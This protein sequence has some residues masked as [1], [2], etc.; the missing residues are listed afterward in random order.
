MSTKITSPFPFSGETTVGVVS[1][2]FTDGVAEFDGTL[3][4]EAAALLRSNG[5]TVSAPL[6]ES[7][8]TVDESPLV[9]VDVDVSGLEDDSAPAKNATKAEWVDYGVTQGHDRGSLEELTRT[10]IQSLFED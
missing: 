9:P 1:L 10:E 8:A 4:Q 6:I 2:E 3:S 7:D 5:F